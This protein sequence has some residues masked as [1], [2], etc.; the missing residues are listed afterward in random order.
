VAKF[1]DIIPSID[2]RLFALPEKLLEQSSALRGFSILSIVRSLPCLDTQRSDL[3]WDTDEAGKSYI[4]GVNKCV[5]R[6]EAIPKDAHLFL[7]DEYPVLALASEQ[8]VLRLHVSIRWTSPG[9]RLTRYK[10]HSQGDISCPQL[11]AVLNS[12]RTGISLEA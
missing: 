12:F 9:K 4:L 6:H 7:V 3:R 2:F 5:L 11:F 8:L 1:F 10:L